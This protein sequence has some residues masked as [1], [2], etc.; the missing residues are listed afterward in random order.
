M[1][2]EIMREG[3]HI[4]GS[5]DSLTASANESQSGH[6]PGPWRAGLGDDQSPRHGEFELACLEHH[7]FGTGIYAP[8]DYYSENYAEHEANARLIAAA[9][10]LLAACKRAL[11]DEGALVGAT[12]RGE[13][14]AAIAKAEGR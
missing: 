7:V 5:T 10:D 12:R 11:E 8:G 13:I 3:E 14:R 2:K 9:P 4:T 6:T 1:K